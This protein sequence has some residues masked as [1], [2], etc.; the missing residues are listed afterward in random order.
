MNEVPFDRICSRSRTRVIQ[1]T[2]GH[3][4]RPCC[5]GKVVDRVLCDG[6]TG[7]GIG[8]KKTDDGSR[9]GG[10]GIWGGAEE[11]PDHV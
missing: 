5:V 3:C 4:C 6:L 9:G 11:V 2:D 8:R 10:I 7:K 1:P